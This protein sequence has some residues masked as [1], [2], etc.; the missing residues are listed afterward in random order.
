MTLFLPKKNLESL[1]C[2]RRSFSLALFKFSTLN[3]KKCS[4]RNEF[5]VGGGGGHRPRGHA[6]P[7]KKFGVSHEGP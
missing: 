1:Y 5:L 3:T 4:G 2:V 6:P 7:Q